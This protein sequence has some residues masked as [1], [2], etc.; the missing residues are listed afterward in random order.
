MNIPINCLLKH[1]DKCREEATKDGNSTQNDYEIGFMY[2]IFYMLD[3][4]QLL[5]KDYEKKNEVFK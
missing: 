5:L 4:F 3:N 1:I 2:G